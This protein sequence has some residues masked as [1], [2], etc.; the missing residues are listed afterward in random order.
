MCVYDDICTWLKILIGNVLLL[1]SKFA[2]HIILT[3]SVYMRL[4]INHLIGGLR[5]DK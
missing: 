1:P 4:V 3:L 2:D 5:I